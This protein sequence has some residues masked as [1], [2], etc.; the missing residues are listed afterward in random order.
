MTCKRYEQMILLEQSGELPVE[1]SEGLRRHIDSCP[2]C[3]NY[4]K[5]YGNLI[6]TAG[7]IMQE[8]P[9]DFAIA[10]VM[11]RINGG[12]DRS[13]NAFVHW[14][15]IAWTISAV[16]ALVV[17]IFIFQ[18]QMKPNA[19]TDRVV[20]VYDLLT[21]LSDHDDVNTTSVEEEHSE[22]LRNLATEL[23]RLE[24]FAEDSGETDWFG[25]LIGDV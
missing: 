19:R 12:N 3:R 7:K 21:F 11:K 25:L 18:W 8:N 6:H 14:R 22:N 2:T 10:A 23:L 5:F 24:G 13:F 9:S 1:E 16:A 17:A 20:Q 15:S 4:M